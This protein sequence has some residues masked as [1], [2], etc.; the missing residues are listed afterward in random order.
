M[1]ELSPPPW[2]GGVVFWMEQISRNDISE[3][4][5]ISMK[6]VKNVM[7]KP[8]YGGGTSCLSPG[9]NPPALPRLP[10]DCI[11]PK[12]LIQNFA[13]QPRFKKIRADLISRMAEVIIFRVDLISRMA[14]VIIFRVDLISRIV[15]EICEIAEFYTREI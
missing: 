5:P 10:L 6:S 14:E 7:K 4:T 9:N 3:K 8:I 12:T 13:N 15:S 2:G 1:Y 11:L